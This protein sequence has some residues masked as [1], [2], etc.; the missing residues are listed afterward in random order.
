MQRVRPG[1]KV[2]VGQEQGSVLVA[3]GDVAF[4]EL[5]ERVCRFELQ[6]GK[7]QRDWYQPA[8]GKYGHDELRLLND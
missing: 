7:Y 4:V 8:D 1:D 2:L 6:D 3:E 5:G